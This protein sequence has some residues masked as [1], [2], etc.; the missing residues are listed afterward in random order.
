MPTLGLPSTAGTRPHLDV[1]AAND[2]HPQ[3]VFLVLRLGIVQDH[4][5]VTVWAARGEWYGDF[6]IYP[7][8]NRSYD[9]LPVCRTR[10]APRR[11]G[12]GLG[13]S[14]RKWRGASLIGPQ[15]F[16]QLLPQALDLCQRA[17]QLPL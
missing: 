5:A 17:L 8:G 9:P 4:R 7:A 11:L 15:G 10:L 3:D 1:K 2:G 13:I 6:L 16:F 14:L 12:V